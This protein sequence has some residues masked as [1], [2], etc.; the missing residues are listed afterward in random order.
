[1]VVTAAATAVRR[2]DLYMPQTHAE[3][4]QVVRAAARELLLGEIGTMAFCLICN[5]ALDGLAGSGP[6]D[7]LLLEVFWAVEAWE[8]PGPSRIDA[9]DR[10]RE[11]AHRIEAEQLA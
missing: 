2:H 1:M 10:L 8:P 5:G 6:L 7:G 11:L 3:A 9:T 4:V